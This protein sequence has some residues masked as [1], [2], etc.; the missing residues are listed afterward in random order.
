MVNHTASILFLRQNWRADLE[1]VGE[2][3][4]GPEENAVT[5]P[6]FKHHLSANNDSI[7]SAQSFANPA[8]KV[9]N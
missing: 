6:A 3:D 1:M 5:T 9:L 4:L 2:V 8:L 7:R